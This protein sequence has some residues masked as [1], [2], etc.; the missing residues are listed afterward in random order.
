MHS[1]SCATLRQQHRATRRV[2][3]LEPCYHRSRA[4]DASGRLLQLGLSKTSTRAIRCLPMLCRFP[5][6]ASM[7]CAVHASATRFGSSH[8]IDRGRV[9]PTRSSIR[10][11]S[12]VSSFLDSDR[13]GRYASEE[14]R[15]L[16]PSTRESRRLSTSRNA[17]LRQPSSRELG[18]DDRTKSFAVPSALSPKIR[19]PWARSPDPTQPQPGQSAR[20]KRHLPVSASSRKHEHTSR[21]IEPRSSGNLFSSCRLP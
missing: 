17:F 12:D 9:V 2:S 20:S 19:E 3:L 14:P 11:A 18:N 13:A 5:C 16:P 4:E 21:T 15:R 6:A 8:S 7:S 1:V 10:L